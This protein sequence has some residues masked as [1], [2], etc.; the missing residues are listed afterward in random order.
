M[1]VPLL[2][3][4]AQYAT[5]RTEVRDAI[6]RVCESQGFILGP[7]VA[8]LEE[9]VAAFC[10][11]RYAVGVSSGTDAL[12]AALMA[13]GVGP[14]DEVITTAYSFFAT[15]G[16]IARLGARPVFV[17]IDPRSFNLDTG[18]LE[19]R[20]TPRT[21]AIMPVH[22]FGRCCDLETVAAVAEAHGLAVV[23]DAA[24]AI[25][26]HD[27]RGRNAGTVGAAGCLS[28]FPSKNLGAF[29]DGGMVLSNDP[30]LAER[31][32]VVRV[33]GSKPKYYHSIVGGNFRLDAIQAA[34][35]RV[36]LKYLTA[37]TK[38]RRENAERYRLLFEDAGLADRVVLPEDRPGHIYNQF[39]IRCPERD[40]LQ[41]FLGERNVGTEIYYPVP[42]HLQHC[43][44]DLGHHDG[45]FPAAEVAARETLALPIYPEL[46]GAAQEYV[47]TQVREFFGR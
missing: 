25:G 43:F 10:E 6:E 24:Q 31:L 2:D 35:L 19:R 30:E 18:M 8:A 11:T 9:E 16:T 17:D 21:K 34:V 4:K 20:I 12:L 47:V 22:L 36:K 13:V 29:G 45:D 44:K 5:I 46:S 37:W 7:E 14:G 27:D 1:K 41:R 38:A 42:L 26:A 15:A 39:V 23:E 28:F 32:K 40:A 3:L 33:H